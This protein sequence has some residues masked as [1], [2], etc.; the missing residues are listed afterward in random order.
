[1]PKEPIS[2]KGGLL[3][4]V[5]HRQVTRPD[6][7]LNY[8]ENKKIPTTP[9][10]PSPF[11]RIS[12]DIREMSFSVENHVVTTNIPR[13]TIT[14]VIP[15]DYLKK[16]T[17]SALYQEMLIG[18]EKRLFEKYSKVAWDNYQKGVSKWQKFILSL[19]KMK[20]YTYVGNSPS[21]LRERI[22]TLSNKIFASTNT[23][24]G[25]FVI[26]PHGLL[27]L[28]E[29][30][31]SLEYINPQ[32]A[33]RI[34]DLPNPRFVKRGRI[35]NISV[36][37]DTYAKWDSHDVIVGRTS[38]GHGHPGIYFCEYSNEYQNTEDHLSLGMKVGLISKNVLADVGDLS[39]MYIADKISTKVKP[40]W[41]KILG[42]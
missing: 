5:T 12:V 28:L 31:P 42:I 30:N 39:G 20:K 35:G 37:H 1:M 25:N 19:L 36:Y 7:R 32:S 17:I 29:E 18:T 15:S 23:S 26:L 40:W 22:Y 33:G 24:P 14:D 38:E 9:K 13:K 3:E 4:T 8:F 10:T 34:L 27:T 16:V 2:I 41:M 21:S 6:V 11:D